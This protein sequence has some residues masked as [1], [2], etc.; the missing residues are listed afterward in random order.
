MACVCASAG[1]RTELGEEAAVR[2]DSA[3]RGS[4]EPLPEPH[5]G[6]GLQEEHV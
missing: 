1:G 4:G 3:A 5:G 6:A 2:R